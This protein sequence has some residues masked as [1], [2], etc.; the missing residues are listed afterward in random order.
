MSLH[1]SELYNLR[2]RDWDPEV[3]GLTGLPRSILP[4]VCGVGT[5]LGELGAG[6]QRETGLGPVPVTT[7]ASHD[8]A[9]AFLAAPASGD[10]AVLSS[11]T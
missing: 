2:N 3:V 6:V 4:L 10:C 5:V 7:G 1:Q 9:S 11:G 8:T